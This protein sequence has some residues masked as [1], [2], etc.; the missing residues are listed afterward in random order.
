[1]SIGHDLP[2]GAASTMARRRR[3]VV[4]TVGLWA[5]ADASFEDLK[6]KP[7]EQG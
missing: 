1:L 7:L 2:S 3:G 4:V 5:E 6:V